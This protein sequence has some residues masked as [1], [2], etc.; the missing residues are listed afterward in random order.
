MTGHLEIVKEFTF[1][2][3]HYFTAAPEGHI[4]GRLHGHSF[5]VAVALG[6]SRD[7]EHG[8]VVDFGEL[9]RALT[10]VRDKLDHNLLNEIEGL[11]NPSLENIAIWLAEKIQPRFPQLKSVTVRRPSCFEAATYHVGAR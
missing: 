10:Q 9:A 3:A 1:E 6:G 7:A 5:H 8:W 11:D 4:Y 2:A